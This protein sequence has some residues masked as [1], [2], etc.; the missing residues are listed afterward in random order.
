[1][2][3]ATPIERPEQQPAPANPPARRRTIN[4]AMREDIGPVVAR[5]VPVTKINWP[6]WWARFVRF[7]WDL[8]M[9][10][11]LAII[12]FAWGSQ[13]IRHV[14]PASGMKLFKLPIP[15]FSELE[16]YET[17]YRLDTAH[18]AALILLVLSWLSWHFLL[19]LHI[20]DELQKKFER[21]SWNL[22]RI[23]PVLIVTATLIIIGD[24]GLF[25]AAFNH[26][27][28]GETRF[29]ATALVASLVYMTILVLVNFISLY[30]SHCAKD[31][32]ETPT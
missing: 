25:Y 28:F 27:A 22:A 9:T 13:G 3:T 18:F 14:L 5:F 16:H 11:I 30:F 31:K 24:G 1:M 21:W 29:S 7:M 19:R 12:Y 20:S 8:V 17:T 15:G 4:D 2:S 6:L 32:K 23:K 10:I 26:A